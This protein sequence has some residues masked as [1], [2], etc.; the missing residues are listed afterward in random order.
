MIAGSQPKTRENEKEIKKIKFQLYENLSNGS[1][2]YTYTHNRVGVYEKTLDGFVQF[3]T[4]TTF[5]PSRQPTVGGS[6]T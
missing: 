2:H 1:I 5:S 6:A 3:S 4:R